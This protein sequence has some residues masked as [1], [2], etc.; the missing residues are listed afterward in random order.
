MERIT[1]PAT[2]DP[3]G[4]LEAGNILYFPGQG[5]GLT[6]D[7]TEFL[8]GVHNTGGALHKNVAYRPAQDRVSGFEAQTP[9]FADRLRAIMRKYSQW[10]VSFTG[11]V[12]PRYSAKWHLD[13]ASFRPLEEEGRD[14][15]WKKRNDL[16]HV[17]A[18]PSRP[19]NGGMILR[20]FTNIHPVKVRVWIVSD[21]FEPL[22]QSYADSAGLRQVVE[23]VGSGVDRLKRGVTRAL[24][25][26]KVPVVDRSPYDRF[27]LGFHD[28]LKANADYQKDCAKYRFE[29]PPN[30]TWMVFTDVVPHAVLSGQS[31]LEQTFIVSPE[32]LSRPQFA[33]VAI[34]ERLSG[35]RLRD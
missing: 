31:A 5:T 12:L 19:T 11:G 3:H 4:A 34:L 30:S 33:P 35:A 28:F 8:L 17:D 2:S 14:L 25:S 10:A 6:A 27:M 7:E 22:A 15:P 20:V 16:L 9:E 13:Y 18:F 32:S 23:Q 24:H 29:F 21:P 26:A 1:A